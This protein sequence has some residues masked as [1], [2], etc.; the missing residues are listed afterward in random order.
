MARIKRNI[1]RSRSLSF[2]VSKPWLSFPC[3][4][5]ADDLLEM[6]H[7]RPN[8]NHLVDR[9]RVVLDT[10]DEVLRQYFVQVSLL[11]INFGTGLGML[12]YPQK[13]SIHLDLR[14]WFMVFI[15]ITITNSWVP[16]QFPIPVKKSQLQTPKWLEH[17]INYYYDDCKCNCKV[18]IV[19]HTTR[20]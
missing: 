18:R 7:Q 14:F 11:L 4:I 19:L 20:S 9:Y 6:R 8:Y 16:F 3:M 10:V 12:S 2:S 13:I 1:S 17:S 15:L 5:C